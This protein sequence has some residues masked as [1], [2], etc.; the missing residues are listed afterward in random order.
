VTSS[1]LIPEPAVSERRFPLWYV[2]LCVLTVLLALQ[3]AAEIRATAVLARPERAWTGIV[4]PTGVVWDIVRVREAGGFPVEGVEPGSP[5]ALAGLRTGDLILS[6]DGVRVEEHPEIYFR[7]VSGGE[8]GQAVVLLWRRVGDE[9]DGILTF[10]RGLP[11]AAGVSPWSRYG[12]YLLPPV[13]MTIVGVWIGFARTRDRMAF[14][15]ALL[16][17]MLAQSLS[18]F[19]ERAPMLT[20]WPMWA[21]GGTIVAARL[22]IYPLALLVI[23]VLAVFPSPSALGRWILRRRWLLLPYALLSAESVLEAVGRL[24]GVNTLPPAVASALDRLLPWTYMWLA[25][26][27]FSAALIVA[28]RVEARS[29]R[30][31]RLGI[32]QAG[33]AGTALGGF[34]VLFLWNSGGFWDLVASPESAVLSGVLRVLATLIPVLLLCALPLSLGYAALARRVFGIR[35][36]VRRGIRYLLLSRGVLLLEGLLL[37]IVLGEAIH[38]SQRQV[39]SSIPAVTGIAGAATILALLVLA[40]VNRPIMRAIDKRFFRESYDARRLLL[41]LGQEMLTLREKEDVLTRAGAVLLETLHASRVAFLLRDHASGEFRLAWQTPAATGAADVGATSGHV[42]EGLAAFED[43][44]RSWDI[45]VARAASATPDASAPFELLIALRG[46][47]GLFGCIAL[48]AKRSDEPYGREDRQLLVTVATQLGF[49]LENADLLDIAMREAE[50]ARELAIAHRVQE[51]LYPTTLPEPDGW[52]FAAI[53]RPARAVGGDYYDLFALDPGHVVIALG[54]VAGKGLG[55][56][57]VMSAVQ[58]LIRSH[59]RRSLEDLTDLVREL[60]EHILA[61]SSAETFVTLFVGVLDVASGRLR[62]VNAGHN[63]PLLVRSVGADQD[64][65]EGGMPVGMLA[66]ATYIEGE[67]VV[68]PGSLLVIYSDGVTEAR[69]RAGG[70]FGEERLTREVAASVTR[71]AAG[72]LDAILASV[73]RF[74]EGTEQADDLS[75]VVARRRP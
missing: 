42:Q 16:L 3:L 63:P 30:E 27:L 13:L 48:G 54:D 7:A 49:A 61:S 39:S 11:A 10:D 18:V 5:G 25:L 4:G 70:F 38:V 8:Q 41:E 6:V 40:R 52:E 45:P 57:L 64:L 34:C 65:T 74:A 9:E 2:A 35:V 71:G 14:Q 15:V 43:G 68:E 21:L 62:Y 36:I 60:N 31:V 23:Q 56:S 59:V 55:P 75:V 67:T 46:S 37:F 17:L 29:R 1:L 28:Q 26:L 47:V 22:A 19:V 44:G 73:D 72:A 12:P 50:Q 24:Y 66:G 33:L 20:V 51:A 53:C 32:V 58:A 69:D